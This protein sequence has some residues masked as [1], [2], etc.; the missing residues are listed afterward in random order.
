MD[1]QRFVH[2]Q[3]ATK[4]KFIVLPS[5]MYR[6]AHSKEL[7]E[8]FECVFVIVFVK[9]LFQVF[10]HLASISTLQKEYKNHVSHCSR[11]HI[12]CNVGSSSPPKNLTAVLLPKRAMGV[13]SFFLTH[14][15]YTFWVLGSIGFRKKL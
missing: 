1:P 9:L 14:V 4:D 15:S 6:Q 7:Q 3:V 5:H 12:C 2:L 10:F 8:L 13:T 11:S